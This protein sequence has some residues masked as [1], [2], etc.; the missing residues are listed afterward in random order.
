VF[1][2]GLHAAQG[3]LF[4]GLLLRSEFTGDARSLLFTGTVLAALAP[5]TFRTRAALGPGTTFG[6]CCAFR[7]RATL[8]PVATFGACC[9]FRTRAALGAITAF[10][11]RATLGAITAFRTRATI[12]AGR[13]FIAIAWFRPR[14]AFRSRAAIAAA[15]F[16]LAW[17]P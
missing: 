13:P 14:A 17:L 9:A 11:T 3:F 16:T 4:L 10:R 5:T 2:F 7:T 15:W 8:G 12:G 6:T 1:S